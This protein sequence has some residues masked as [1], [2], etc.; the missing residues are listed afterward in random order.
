MASVPPAPTAAARPRW[1]NAG[2]AGVAALTSLAAYAHLIAPHLKGQAVRAGL[3]AVV[4][5]GAYFLFDRVVVRRTLPRLAMYVPGKWRRRGWIVAALLVGGLILAVV[6]VGAPRPPW[7]ARHSLEVVAL[8]E[9][10]AASAST[11]VWLIELLRSDGSTVP[12]TEI[13]CDGEWNVVNGKLVSYQ[14]Q[15]AAF[16]WGPRLEGPAELRL[17]A[18]PFSGL[19]RVTWDGVSQIVDL[20]APTQGGKHIPLPI[21]RGEHIAADVQTAVIYCADAAVLALAVLALSVWVLGL[22]TRPA[23]A[24]RFRWVR[25]GVVCAGAWG[26][27]LVAYWPALLSPDS[28]SQW[29]Q[30]ATGHFDDAHPPVSTF[31]LWLLTR[32]WY[33]PAAIALAQMLVLAAVAGWGLARARAHGA[34]AWLVAIVGLAFALSPANALLVITVWKDIPFSIAMLGLT[35][36]LIE[37]VASESPWLAR[38]WRWLLLGVLGAAVVLYRHNGLP[39][40]VLTGVALLL[41]YPR[42]WIR[43]GLSIGVGVALVWA[44]QGPL[45]RAAKVQR[46][47]L[48]TYWVWPVLHHLA[49]HVSAQTPLEPDERGLIERIRPPGPWP[50]DPYYVDTLFRDGKVHTDNA[51]ALRDDLLRL[52]ARLVWRRPLVTL[53]WLADRASVVWRITQ[54]P[55]SGYYRTALESTTDP[56]VVDVARAQGIS[57]AP[58]WPALQHWYT[59]L[60]DGTQAH[61]NSLIWRP[62]LWMYLFV[63]GALLAAARARNARYLLVCVPV[64]VNSAFLAALA[65]GQDFRYQFPAYVVGLLLALLLPFAAPRRAIGADVAATTGLDSQ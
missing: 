33:S 54:P 51:V 12:P 52:S 50:N 45:F 29:V 10:S 20:Y 13:A 8:G 43:V 16:S 5:L 36:L 24:S 65:P 42:R 61:A 53:G 9:K 22:D 19:A 38:P 59:D 17:I 21:S 35:L 30:L 37:I 41:A 31:T 58:P 64:L 47:G 49:A 25:Y 46:S 2:A 7:R 28:M 1:L 39:A 32:A 15:P 3:L 40:A 26:V 34:P 55:G 14:Q 11:E 27:A 44:C 63:A 56:R 48:S 60:A 18:H 4:F 23:R 6:P 62:A 57:L